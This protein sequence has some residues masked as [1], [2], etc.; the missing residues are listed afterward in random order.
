MSPSVC[1][2]PCYA[3]DPAHPVPLRAAPISLSFHQWHNPRN[4]ESYLILST[5]LP[6]VAR[7][8]LT[9]HT[10]QPLSNIRLR[11]HNEFVTY[12]PAR[13]SLTLFAVRAFQRPT[14]RQDSSPAAAKELRLLLFTEIIIQILHGHEIA[15]LM[16]LFLTPSYTQPSYTQPS[17]ASA[18]PISY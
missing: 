11:S 9:L 12:S 1:P 6:Y 5:S 18:C 17:E 2:T 13:S 10:T 16:I 3:A 15:S 14:P 8:V 4:Q 7:C